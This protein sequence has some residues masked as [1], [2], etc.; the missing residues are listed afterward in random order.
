MDNSTVR[1]IALQAAVDTKT[2]DDNL[3]TIVARAE[4]FYEFLQK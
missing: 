2:P 4:K 1:E 3:D